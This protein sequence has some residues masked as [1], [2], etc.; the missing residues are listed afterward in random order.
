MGKKEGVE[1][2][3][4]NGAKRTTG[5]KPGKMPNLEFPVK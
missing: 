5:A 3:I 1:N 2:V 4:I